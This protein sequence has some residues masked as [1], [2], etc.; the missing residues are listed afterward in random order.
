MQ[1]GNYGSL[2]QGESN[3]DGVKLLDSEGRAHKICQWPAVY[4]I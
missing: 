4:G 2:D 3:G 1:M